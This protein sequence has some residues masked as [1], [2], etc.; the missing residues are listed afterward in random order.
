MIG[1]AHRKGSPD[2]KDLVPFK[3]NFAFLNSGASNSRKQFTGTL[4]GVIGITAV[5]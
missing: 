4:R 5:A 3:E 1:N 2:P